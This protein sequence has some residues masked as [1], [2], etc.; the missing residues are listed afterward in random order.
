MLLVRLAAAQQPAK[1]IL[2][3]TGSVT[4]ATL[5]CWR[6]GSYE[7][8]SRSLSLSLRKDCTAFDRKEKVN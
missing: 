4:V 3:M 5:V 7:Q 6:K 1:A 8:V 2:A